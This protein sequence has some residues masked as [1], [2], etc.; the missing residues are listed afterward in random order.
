MLDRRQ[1]PYLLKLLDDD[2]PQVREQVLD[3]LAAFGD[4][5]EAELIQLPV[6]PENHQVL[7]IKGLLARHLWGEVRELAVAES[8]S[9]AADSAPLFYAGQ[10][11]YH[12][13]YGYRGVVVDVDPSCMA[14]DSWYAAGESQPD[15][16]QPWYH[17]L[18]HNSMQ[19]TY[20]AQSSLSTDDTGDEVVH[21][22][23]PY[24]FSEFRDGDYIR[25]D[26]P[27]PS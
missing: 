23:V 9:M 15:R 27:W 3:A 20:A 1:L 22:Y 12:A 7:H 18:V 24:F 13:I 25:N 4:D 2:S 19:V 6:P 26:Q 14:D 8:D 11:V 21:P 16:H 17:V 5:L 10:V